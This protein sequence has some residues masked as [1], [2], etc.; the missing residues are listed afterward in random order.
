MTAGAR[1]LVLGTAQDGGIPHAGCGCTT[2]RSALEDPAKRRSVAS[3]AVLDASGHALVV[4]ATPD[5]P[6]QL[7]AVAD[8]LGRARPTCD[9]ILLTHAHMGHY[10]GLAHLG[11]EAMDVRALPLFATARMEAF[12]AANRPWS[13]LIDRKEVEIRRLK[14]GE[15]FDFGGVALTPFTVPHRA[16]DTDTIGL[17]IEGPRA[18]L[19]YLPDTDLWT[20]EI[21][22]RVC[23]ADVALVD[24]TFYDEGELPG[25]DLSAIPHPFVKESV[26]HLAGARGRVFFTHLNHTNALLLPDPGQRTSLPEGFD[27]LAEGAKFEL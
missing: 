21:V 20:E 11:R 3:L 13:H 4:D 27:L 10:V 5:L 19:L 12:L 22:Q 6:S 2:C 24:G 16:E 15:S 7:R 23:E 14:D 1:A 17:W 18:R 26:E 25:R 9:A 8:A